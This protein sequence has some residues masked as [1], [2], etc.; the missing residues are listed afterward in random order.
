MTGRSN[1]VDDRNVVARTGERLGLAR[2]AADASFRRHSRTRA[3]VPRL[4]RPADGIREP[5]VSSPRWCTA[6]A[7][8]AR[9][10]R[11]AHE[12]RRRRATHAG[13]DASS[14]A[15]PSGSSRSR[16]SVTYALADR[17][18]VAIRAE[19][20]FEIRRMRRRSARLA[21]RPRERVELGAA[22][23]ARSPSAFPPADDASAAARAPVLRAPPTRPTLRRSPRRRSP[24]R[25]PARPECRALLQLVGERARA[26][27]LDERH[28]RPAEQ[29][30]LLPRRD[31][32]ALA[33]GAALQSLGGERRSPETPARDRHTS[34][35][36]RSPAP[37]R[38]TRAIRRR[39]ASARYHSP[40]LP[41]AR[42]AR[43]RRPAER[44]RAN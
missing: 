34:S 22:R 20:Q 6:A 41:G 26:Q 29:A 1:T 32:D 25:T 4:P 43:Q 16:S 38:R 17:R 15:M 10:V 31:D 21:Q 33:A 14:T 8:V 18:A 24:P 42:R 11:R 27:R 40:Q 2:A 7:S 23:A 44:F 37:R 36:K 19:R 13:C 5:R 30:G 9:V 3:T 35:L 39:A 12:Q 28:Q